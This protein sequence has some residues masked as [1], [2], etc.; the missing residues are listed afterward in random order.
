MTNSD[1]VLSNNRYS[2][3]EFEQISIFL[4]YV[5]STNYKVLSISGYELVA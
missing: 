4:Q 3:A 5:F 2:I 1:P